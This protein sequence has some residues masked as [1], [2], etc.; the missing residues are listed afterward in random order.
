MTMEEY[1]KLKEAKDKIKAMN[2]DLDNIR[3]KTYDSN[4]RLRANF[5][6]MKDFCKKH[7]GIDIIL[8]DGEY[9]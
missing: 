5:R 8:S 3:L 6:E 1:E 9:I 2:T 7:F 4:G